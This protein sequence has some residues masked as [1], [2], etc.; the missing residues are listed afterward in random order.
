VIVESLGA[1]PQQSGAK[2]AGGKLSVT[3]KLDAF[4][5]ES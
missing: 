1:A 5:K 2:D 4:V 3:L